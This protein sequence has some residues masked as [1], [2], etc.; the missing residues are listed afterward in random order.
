MLFNPLGNPL[1]PPLVAVA[2]VYG[3]VDSQKIG[4]IAI[5][6]EGETGTL[7]EGYTLSDGD[8]FNSLSLV[9][10]ATPSADYFA[11][12]AYRSEGG[13]GPAP[14]LRAPATGALNVMHDVSPDYT[15]WQDQARGVAQSYD[16]HSIQSGALRL[17]AIRQT[18]GE[19]TNLASGVAGQVERGSMIHTAGRLWWN[20]PAVI[21]WRAKF[22]KG[23]A[24]Q[25]PTVWALS[26]QPP[27]GTM[28]GNEYGFEGSGNDQQAYHG[29]WTAG[30]AGFN[31]QNLTDTYRDGNAHTYSVVVGA[32]NYKY[33][34]DGTLVHTISVDP[35]TA[36]SN[37]ADYALI[38]NHVYKSTFLGENY[39]A[40]AWAADSDGVNIDVEWMRVWR[41]T[42]TGVHYSPLTSIADTELAHG[43]TS[44]IVLPSQSAL[45]GA[46]GLTEYVFAIPNEVEEPGGSNTGSYDQFPTGVTY[47]S[48]TRTI[49]IA[50]TLTGAGC[51]H[52]AVGVTGD[53]I[54]CK[55]ARFRLYVAPR[56]VG[57]AS[58]AW[59]QDVAV[60]VDVY[61][62]WDVGRLF[63]TSGDPKGLTVSGLP[64]GM[65]FSATT[66]LITGTPTASASG[67]LTITATNSKGQTT[68]R[69]QGYVV[70]A[71]ASGVAAPSLTGSPTLIASWDFGDSSK[72]TLDGSNITSVSGSDGTSY[73]IASTGTNRPTQATTDGKTVARFASASAQY[74]QIASAF[75][76]PSA[77]SIVV[78]QKPTSAAAAMTIAELGTGAAAFINDRRLLLAST[79]TGY[80]SRKHDNS[81]TQSIASQ[82]SAYDTTKRCLI[83]VY[84]SGS[85]VAAELNVDGQGTAIVGTPVSN[86]ALGPSFFTL[87]AG[88]DSGAQTRPANMDCFRVLVYSAALNATQREEVATWAASNYGTANNA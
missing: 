80:Q 27:G 17:K 40:A 31:T 22:P 51:L 78:I 32:S 68:S 20:S 25:H 39:S 4:G 76:A 84:P 10:A 54:T 63:R 66:G 6:A 75:G 62:A 14:G 33:Y 81:S 35:D 57:D 70:S 71:A 60:E 79:T 18:A 65:S 69:T 26:V 30:S 44:S 19:Q 2:G 52:F 43:A 73:T 7:Y 86:A 1:A 11:T 72:L 55:P 53:G 24:G 50:N 16:S 74:L 28:T 23:P 9:S 85:S 58:F 29:T 82:G 8:E 49:S 64:S 48:G 47:D 12:R 5:G 77:L 13:S 42:S 15:G 88:R 34:V 45:W 83:G 3:R 41:P 67:D 37:K 87:G 56:W 38:T 21:E 36:G 61:E 46:T 59:Q